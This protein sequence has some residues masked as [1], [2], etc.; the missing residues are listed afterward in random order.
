[1]NRAGITS[2]LIS[3]TP[4]EEI[5][6]GKFA[7]AYPGGLAFPKKILVCNRHSIMSL[8]LVDLSS[9]ETYYIFEYGEMR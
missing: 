8:F 2:P 7:F 3:R 1:M 9:A 5:V 6:A 4:L